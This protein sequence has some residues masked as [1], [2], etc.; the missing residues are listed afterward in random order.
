VLLRGWGARESRREAVALLLREY[1][2][3][4][5]V[6]EAE[7]ERFSQ[8]RVLDDILSGRGGDALVARL[9]GGA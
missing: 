8:G 1:L 7:A 5:S 4:H 2:R 9:V 6:D 3:A